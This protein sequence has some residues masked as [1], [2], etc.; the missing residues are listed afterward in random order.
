VIRIKLLNKKDL[1]RVEGPRTFEGCFKI[2]LIVHSVVP[3]KKLI[4]LMFIGI[5][6]DV[7]R[8]GPNLSRYTRSINCYILER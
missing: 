2:L 6:M 1:K 4:D 8:P 5:L 7:P 3:I